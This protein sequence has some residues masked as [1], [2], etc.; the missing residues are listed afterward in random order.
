M[1]CPGQWQRTLDAI[2]DLAQEIARLSPD[3]ADRAMQIARLVR[4]LEP[5]SGEEP[6]AED[7]DDPGAEPEVGPLT[8]M[9]AFH[10]PR[11]S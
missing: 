11:A 9:H 7:E 1:T 3:C 2:L 4:D 10:R 8:R 5:P 6:F